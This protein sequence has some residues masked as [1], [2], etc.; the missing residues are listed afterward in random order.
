MKSATSFLGF[1]IGD[2]LSQ[3][4]SGGAFDTKRMLR[5]M[6]FGM[7]MDGPVGHVWYTTLDKNVFPENPTCTKA[8]LA[9]TFLD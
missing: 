6:M 3:S 7:M 8:V 2:I 9:K 1:A 5:M 4:L